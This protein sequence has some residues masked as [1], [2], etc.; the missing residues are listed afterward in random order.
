[1]MG[2]GYGR[3]PGS[4]V[5]ICSLS[6]SISISGGGSSSSVAFIVLFGRR[7]RVSSKCRRLI[8][9]N[10]TRLNGNAPIAVIPNGL[11]DAKMAAVSRPSSP[12]M[13]ETLL[14]DGLA[15]VSVLFVIMNSLC[16]G[17]VGILFARSF[18][19]T[20]WVA[21]PIEVAAAINAKVVMHA[22]HIGFSYSV[23][24][25]DERANGFGT[26]SSNFF[27]VISEMG[28][29]FDE[30]IHHTLGTMPRDSLAA[31]IAG[32]EQLPLRL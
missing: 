19:A 27:L 17:S 31:K 26:L 8:W 2:G 11:V 29:G 21:P 3:A 14:V 20:S 5:S 9:P 18:F 15:M 22:G 32:G 25:C 6:A 16:L 7:L 13:R 24:L 1:M 10:A 23:Q 28:R 30:D 4:F 12:S